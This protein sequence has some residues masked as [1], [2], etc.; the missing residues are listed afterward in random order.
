MPFV[1][2]L[3]FINN[4]TDYMSQKMSEKVGRKKNKGKYFAKIWGKNSRIPRKI[5]GIF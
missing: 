2:L 5:A 3:R 4:S 1:D